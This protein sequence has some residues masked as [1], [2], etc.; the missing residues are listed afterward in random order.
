MVSSRILYRMKVLILA[1]DFPPFV[2]VGGLR[3][4]GWY[5]YLGRYGVE[6]VVVTRQWGNHYGDERDYICPSPTAEV[7]VEESS[8]G[9]IIRTPYRPTLSN[10]MM[11]RFGPHRFSL[12]RRTL[13]AFHE[14]G[15]YYIPVGTRI[16]LYR[17]AHEHLSTRGADAIVATGEPFVLFRYAS[18]L[19]RKFG[20]PWI[21]DYRDPWSQDKRRARPG[22]GRR[23]TETV[24]RRSTAGASALVAVSPAVG[25]LLHELHGGKRIEVIPNGY[26]PDAMATA[27]NIPQ[28]HDRLRIAFTG[29]IYDWH[30][31][32]S[33]F[34]VLE[35][36]LASRASPDVELQM[37]GLHRRGPVEELAR[38]FPT[39]A[40]HITFVPR[41][42]NDEM[43]RKLA[44]ANLFLLFNNYADIGT[45]VYDYL[46]LRRR[47]LLCYSDDPE[48]QILRSRHYHLEFP[49][50][51]DDRALER[52]VRK[53]ESGVVVRDAAHLGRVL[54]ETHRE[55]RQ[56]G[57]V[58]CSSVGVE[59][60][61]R[62]GQTELM[63]NLLHEV[64]A[65][66]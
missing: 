23:W 8:Q 3:P 59:Q 58:A 48:A 22:L 9:T 37:V 64:T 40:S 43:A 51:T 41:L 15:Q 61:S 31:V 56:R 39:L 25:K 29:T 10:R 38:R 46:A 14:I 63:A 44:R 47:I 33:V 1:Y 24:E 17:A 45:K 49:A 52:I 20:I 21:G 65:K 66:R 36:F 26:D 13:S 11:L 54:E 35:G 55:F 42:S 12:L 18:L 2:S 4:F 27:T 6:P 30:P 57:A 16:G 32:E 34:R 62:A 7:E 5:R 19:S 50:G 28:G 60:Y 53:T